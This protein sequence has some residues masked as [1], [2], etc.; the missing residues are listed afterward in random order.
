VRGGAEQGPLASSPPAAA[1]R[2]WLPFWALQATEVAVAVI[3]AD[4]SVHSAN[5]GLLV[6]A[7]IT[8][9]ALAITARG[10][11]GIVRVCGQRLHLA[12]VMTVAVVA[13]LAPVIA[14]VRP[15]IQG[16][17]VVEFGAVGL[18]RVATLTQTSES[19]R[20]VG[21]RRTGPPIIDATARIVTAPTPR[22]TPPAGRL[23]SGTTSTGTAA[24]WA[25]RTAGAAAASGK[26]MAAKH[27]PAAEARVKRSIR[28]AGRIAGRVASSPT[29]SETSPE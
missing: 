27:R 12:L 4:I 29:N 2:R 16:V 17:I 8:L 22:A 11:L 3:F 15:D 1:R 14:A 24:R 5:S 21:S 23:R 25:G 19:V 9:A 28:G 26:R 13:A 7:A 10:P 18:I 6:A 20:G